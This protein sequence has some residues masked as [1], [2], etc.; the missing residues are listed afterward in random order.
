[1]VKRVA[2]KQKAQ[3][4]RKD[5]K[6]CIKH[7]PFVMCEDNDD[8]PSPLPR[9]MRAKQ[10]D[11]ILAGLKHLRAPVEPLLEVIFFVVV[12]CGACSSWCP[13]IADQA[14][15]T[16]VSLLMALPGLDWDRPIE[17]LECFS[18][19][20]SVTKAEWQARCPCVCCLAVRLGAARCP[21]TLF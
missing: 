21:L 4:V 13:D 5:A 6:A 15:A 16:L 1:M 20:M 17:H 2:P 14:V 11:W 19:D 10:R 12:H 7:M 8:E 18:G 9:S 3:Q